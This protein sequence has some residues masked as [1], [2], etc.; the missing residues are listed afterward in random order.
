MA[1]NNR[2][3]YDFNWFINFLLG[4]ALS[5]LGSKEEAIKD[6]TKA[7]EMNPQY[8]EAYLGRG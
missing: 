8:A 4:F 1:Y 3:I 6:F 7:L 5:D 2:G